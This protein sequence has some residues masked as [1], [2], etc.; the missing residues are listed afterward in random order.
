MQELDPNTPL[1]HAMHIDV[2]VARDQAEARLQAAVAAGGTIVDDSGASAAT[3]C[4]TIC[5]WPAWSTS[6]T[7]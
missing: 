6:C 7:S 3:S 1:R 5:S 2:S 4:G